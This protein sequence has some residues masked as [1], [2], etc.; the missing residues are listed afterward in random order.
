MAKEDY[1][2]NYRE[3]VLLIL[4]SVSTILSPMHWLTGHWT[5]LSVSL[6][7]RVKWIR[8]V[9]QPK[10]SGMALSGS[11]NRRFRHFDISQGYPFEMLLWT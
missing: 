4:L 5:R 1:T 9:P 8:S 7:V 2:D 10:V 6:V 3:S 11:T